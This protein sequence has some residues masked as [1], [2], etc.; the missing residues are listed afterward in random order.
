MEQLIEIFRK[1]SEQSLARQV[2]LLIGL[3]MSIALGVGII[4][5][6]RSVDY[7]VL[8]SDLEQKDASRVLEALER[9]N[10]PY[11]LDSRTGL[12][13]VPSSDK[14]EIRLRL[15][16]EGLPAGGERGFK[17]L[18]E[19]QQLGTS[20]FLET[21][22]FNRAL[23]EELARSITTIDSVRSA[24]VHLAIPK[25]SSFIRASKKANASVL[26][27]LHPGRLLDEDQMAGIVYLVASSVPEMEPEGVSVV[28]QRGRLL[29]GR[30]GSSELVAG[31]EQHRFAQSI[32]EKYVESITDILTPIV[33]LGKVR[34]KVVADLNFVSIEETSQNYNP[35]TVA[36]RSEQTV[37]EGRSAVDAGG[38]V[39]ILSEGQA[40][41]AA[42][43][44]T[45]ESAR[46]VRSTRNYEVDHTISHVKE[47]PGSIKR[48]SVAVVVD[49]RTVIQADGTTERSQLTEGEMASIRALVKEAVGFNEAR[50]DSVSVSNV[51]FLEVAT[52]DPLPDT[53][54]WEQPWVREYSKV[55]LG[56]IAMLVLI[57][58]VVRPLVRSMTR[59][60]TLPA[61]VMYESYVGETGDVITRDTYHPGEAASRMSDFDRQLLQVRALVKDDP[62]RV[63]Q[64]IRG[65]VTADA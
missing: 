64:V 58:G 22:R 42:V 46:T 44:A 54:V 1:V 38:P 13:A 56:F 53:P 61:D 18:Y 2:G 10:V 29:S 47:A 6:T 43:S 35:N 48:L 55:G 65:W 32:E 63:A 30:S 31:A 26:V 7:A 40:E 59:S 3:S 33:G 50:G 9:M 25:S 28:D 17:V 5:W 4:L 34:A 8:Y 45:G 37:T 57:L 52:A 36:I 15:A 27:N 23:E 14:H 19:D 51:P 41:N 24:R 60:E 62:D 21:A 11:E 16:G 20:S 12:I 39:E 49:Y